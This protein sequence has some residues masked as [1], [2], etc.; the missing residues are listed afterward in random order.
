MLNKKKTLTLIAILI[1]VILSLA[2]ILTGGG[3]SLNK[4]E[5][6]GKTL[7]IK[8]NGSLYGFTSGEKYGIESTIVGR[9]LDVTLDGVEITKDLSNMKSPNKDDEEFLENGNLKDGYNIIRMD[10]TIKNKGD[11]EE[12]LN[13]FSNLTG[14]EYS[15]WK[16]VATELNEEN[17]IHSPYLYKINPG[18]VK[19]ISIGFVSSDEDFEK[20]K[21]SELSYQIRLP[22][23]EKVKDKEEDQVEYQVEYFYFNIDK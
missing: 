18:E 4:V 7:K 21:N 6:G 9:Y 12:E 20:A 3:T 17:L 22:L 13:L 10:F 23:R 15:E 2:Y 8:Q 1:L 19:N 16:E 5:V 14:E 11:Q